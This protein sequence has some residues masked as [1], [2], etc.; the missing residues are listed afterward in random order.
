MGLPGPTRPWLRRF[1]SALRR[2]EDYGRGTP[3]LTPQSGKGWRLE[4]N[5]G[6]VALGSLQLQQLSGTSALE[7]ESLL[8]DGV[9]TKALM[10]Y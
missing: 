4:P 9:F 1:Q 6:S 7:I 10:H 5:P 3:G 2:P 8:A